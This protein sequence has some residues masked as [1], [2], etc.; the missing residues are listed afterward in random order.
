MRPCRLAVVV[1]MTPYPPAI[2]RRAER[3][4]EASAVLPAV[5][6]TCGGQGWWRWSGRVCARLR[7]GCVAANTVVTCVTR[8][9]SM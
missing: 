7:S 1:A 4:E 6:E 5:E 8:R 3:L 2:T 9:D